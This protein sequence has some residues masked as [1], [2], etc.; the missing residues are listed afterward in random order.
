MAEYTILSA[1]LREEL[2]ALIRE[3]LAEGTQT[4][5]RLRQ[6]TG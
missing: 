2:K 1:P 5:S 4:G 6:R 3:V